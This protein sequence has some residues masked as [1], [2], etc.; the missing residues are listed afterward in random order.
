MDREGAPLHPG[1]GLVSPPPHHDIYSIEDLAE[2][3]HDLK[4]ANP[5]ARINVKLVAE[6][7]VGTIASGVAKAHADVIS[8]P[9]TTVARA[10][11]RPRRSTTPGLRG[12]SD[13]PKR[14]RSFSSTTS[15][16]ASSSRRMAS[17]RPVVT[18]PS[19]PCSEP[20]STVR[21]RAARLGGLSHDARLPEKHLSVGVATQDPKLRKNFTGKPEHVVN[22]MTFIARS[23]ANTWP[24]S[25]SV[26]SMK[27][28]VTSSASTRTRRPTTGKQGCRPHHR[29]PQPDVGEEVGTYCQKAQDHGLDK[30]L[31][32]TISLRSASPR[33]SG[34]KRSMP[35]CRSSTSTAS[36]A[37]S[38][39]AR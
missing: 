2:L 4:N 30:A 15:A 10:R 19:P 23:C 31:D 17:S 9:V 25:V 3:I 34:A 1:V 16:A 22:F 39:A 37:P 36:S 6:V 8:S 11:P 14:T 20:R 28:L 27:W 13:S 5:R 21:D 29:L 18:S 24:S 38:P 35:S 32:N 12:N 26:R 33:Y 7:G